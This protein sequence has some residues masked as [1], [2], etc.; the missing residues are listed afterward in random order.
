MNNPLAGTDPTG[1]VSKCNQNPTCQMQSFFS[2]VGSGGSSL[3]GNLMGRLKTTLTN[4]HDAKQA[5]KTQEPKAAAAVNSPVAETS[6]NINQDMHPDGG[7]PRKADPFGERN[8]GDLTAC[9][10]VCAVPVVIGINEIMIGVGITAVAVTVSSIDPATVDSFIADATKENMRGASESAT[11]GPG[12]D[13]DNENNQSD[14]SGFATDKEAEHYATKEL[15]FKKT[16]F[17]SHGQ[18]VFKKGNRYITRDAD[19]HNGG[20]WK[21][22]DSVKNLGSR[23]TRIGTFSRNLTKIGD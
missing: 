16:N 21:M 9:L 17:R 8:I 5:K 12:Q 3:I 13:P 23:K 20:A 15:G 19:S 22:A 18:K 10:P 4:G 7:K 6:V 14:N 1:Y 2:S 11:G